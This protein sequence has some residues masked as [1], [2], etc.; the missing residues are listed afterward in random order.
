MTF[1]DLL[2]PGSAAGFHERFAAFKAGEPA[3]DLELEMVRKDGSVLPAN[4]IVSMARD[5]AGAPEI[6]IA[7]RLP[8]CFV[9]ASS[10]SGRSRT[11]ARAVHS[12]R[13]VAAAAISTKT[14]RSRLTSVARG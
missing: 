10:T 7:N 2:A 5:K 13:A 9:A 14:M 8:F 11:S 4:L 1:P 12:A 6:M 3:K